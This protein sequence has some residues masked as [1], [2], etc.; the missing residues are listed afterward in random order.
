MN[1]SA[2][3]VSNMMHNTQGLT[4]EGSKGFTHMVMQFGQF[5]DHDITLTPEGGR[6]S[7]SLNHF[8]LHKEENYF[9]IIQNVLKVIDNYP[10]SWSVVMK[11]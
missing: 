7:E 11:K 8:N 5:L 2:R 4:T 1:V 10:Q 6:F 3:K 9:K